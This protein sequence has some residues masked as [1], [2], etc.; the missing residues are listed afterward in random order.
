MSGITDKE[1]GATSARYTAG[2]IKRASRR[3]PSYKLG[4]DEPRRAHSTWYRGEH[5]NYIPSASN[6][7]EDDAVE[8]YVLHGWAPERPFITRHHTITAFGSCFA[9]HLTRYLQERRYDVCGEFGE[10]HVVHHGAGMVNTYA[11]R[12]QLEWAYDEVDIGEDLWHDKR[13]VAAERSLEI[14]QN[15][16][17]LFDA[18][19]VF[20]F[21]L[22]LSEVWYNRDTGNVYWRGIP[23][24][25]FDPKRHGFRVT[26]VEE[27]RE[28]L[29]R[30]YSIIRAKRP[31]ATIILTLSPVPL[32]ATF[33]PVSCITA[34]VVS[35]AVLRVA[36]D[37]LMREHGT[38]P[39]LY[40]WP[41][42]EIVKEF[43]RDPYDDDN[44]HVKPE[45]VS[46]IM[47]A[48]AKFYLVE[49]ED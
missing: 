5:C 11:L 40:Y 1:L 48:F 18:T 38:D 6:L 47:D 17:R 24:L 22:G 31:G 20:I 23:R 19:D 8:K 44:R 30:I 4:D 34:N 3:R 36:V 15:T 27:N 41:S 13:G 16:R 42:Y 21:T 32:V 28:N 26:T 12:Q 10:T 37:E 14:K 49:T 29:E 35:K 2:E 25:E 33:R 46:R 45:I 9:T 43:C 7:R 39:E